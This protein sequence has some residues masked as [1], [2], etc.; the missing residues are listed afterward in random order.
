MAENKKSVLLYCDLIHTVEKLTDEDAG[1]LFKHYLRYVNDQNPDAPTPIVDIVFEPIK[2]QLKR[3]LVKWDERAER[4][5][6]NGKKGGRPKKNEEPSKTQRVISKPRKPDTVKVTVK[7]TVKVKDIDIKESHPIIDWLNENCPEVQKMKKPITQ[8]EAEKLIIDYK[9]NPAL[10][11][12]TFLSM[13][14][15]APLRK[16]SVSA[17]LTV[18]KWSKKDGSTQ[19]E[20]RQPKRVHKI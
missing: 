10:L 8:S 18:R 9:D 3:D 6:E 5:R 19:M 16:K 4:S 1:K 15:Y 14:N 2:Q 12:E 17:N 7:D 13:E 11:K 20:T